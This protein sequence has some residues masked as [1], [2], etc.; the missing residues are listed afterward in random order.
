LIPLEAGPLETGQRLAEELLRLVVTA[1]R[2]ADGAQGSG[3]VQ[4][5]L[6]LRRMHSIRT[7]RSAVPPPGPLPLGVQ[8]FGIRLAGRREEVVVAGVLLHEAGTLR[9]EP[10]AEALARF[11]GPATVIGESPDEASHHA[12]KTV[13]LERLPQAT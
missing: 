5:N 7:R 3:L 11:D 2:G 1:L 8:H 12:I 6:R 13:L 9:A 10:L 4:P